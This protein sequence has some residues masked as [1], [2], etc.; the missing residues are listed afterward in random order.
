MQIRELQLSQK[1][2][3][4]GLE[5]RQTLNQKHLA[6]EIAQVKIYMFTLLIFASAVLFW[7]LV[8]RIT[9]DYFGYF[10]YLSYFGAR[11]LH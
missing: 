1:K 5:N 7:S 9:S 8:T 6:E 3:L 11:M 2:F 4:V 10:E